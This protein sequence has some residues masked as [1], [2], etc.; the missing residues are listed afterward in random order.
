MNLF[1]GIKNECK[2]NVS[3]LKGLVFEVMAISVMLE[4]FCVSL[5]PTLV[6]IVMDILRKLSL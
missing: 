4:V 5:F 1:F 2:C 3:W 6:H